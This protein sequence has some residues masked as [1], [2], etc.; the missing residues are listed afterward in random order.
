MFVGIVDT[1]DFASD[2]TRIDVSTPAEAEELVEALECAGFAHVSVNWHG[3][4]E[5]TRPIILADSGFLDIMGSEK[6]IIDGGEATPLVTVS[7]GAT[8]NLHNI[9]LENGR[10]DDLGG[11][12]FANKSFISLD[13]CSFSGNKSDGSGEFNGYL[14]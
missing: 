7:D 11:V 2:L 8:L 10:A 4:V 12:V 3:R 14:G 5:L 13:D 1:A 6:A 9:S